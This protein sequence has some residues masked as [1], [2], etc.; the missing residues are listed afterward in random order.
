MIQ[1]ND[2]VILKKESSMRVFQAR[3]NGYP[4]LLLLAAMVNFR[5]EHHCLFEPCV[6]FRRPIVLDRQKFYLDSIFGKPYGSQ[7]E[8]DPKT[9]Q[10]ALRNQDFSLEGTVQHLCWKLGLEIPI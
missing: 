7:F 2:F 10:L 1:E 4:L 9:H 5:N 8:V 6:Y 3:K